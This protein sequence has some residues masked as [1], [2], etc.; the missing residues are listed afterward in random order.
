ML[1]II[2]SFVPVT[3]KKRMSSYFRWQNISEE[4]KY[5]TPIDEQLVEQIAQGITRISYLDLT[6]TLTSREVDALAYAL[7]QSPFFYIDKVHLSQESF[8]TA[9]VP[10]LDLL[11]PRSQYIVFQFSQ[12]LLEPLLLQEF[13]GKLWK[14]AALV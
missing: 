10:L 8:I 2:Q 7:K 13:K 4:I 5:N 3:W 6:R 11:A 1:S 14:I 12:P 9:N